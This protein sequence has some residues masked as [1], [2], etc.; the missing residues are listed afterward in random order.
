VI[1]GQIAGGYTIQRVLESFPDL[2]EAA[3]VAALRYATELVD[4]Q[5]ARSA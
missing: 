2:T 1:L 5:A 4:Q 3:V